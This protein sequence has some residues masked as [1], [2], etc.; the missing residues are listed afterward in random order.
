MPQVPARWLTPRSSTART[1]SRQV[2]RPL[3]VTGFDQAT[4]RTWG[5]GFG[6]GVGAGGGGSAEGAA[7]GAGGVG[8][9]R[10]GGGVRRGGRRRRGVADR[11]RWDGRGGGR[12]CGRRLAG[13]DEQRDG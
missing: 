1:R 3:I 4:D 8:G 5:I 2:S 6:L 13:D 11:D 7:G 10:C 9:V 12:R